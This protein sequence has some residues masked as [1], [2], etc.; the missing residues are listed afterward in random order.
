M[1]EGAKKVAH[2][3]RRQEHRA[4]CYVWCEIGEALKCRVLER[5]DV[6][7]IVTLFRAYSEGLS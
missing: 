7:L 2:D 1:M 4:L 5:T 6:Y 3:Q